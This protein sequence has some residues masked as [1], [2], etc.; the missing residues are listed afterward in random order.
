MEMDQRAYFLHLHMIRKHSNCSYNVCRRAATGANTP[1]DQHQQRS[2]S[3]QVC[4]RAVTGENTPREQHRRV[5][6]FAAVFTKKD[7]KYS[8]MDRKNKQGK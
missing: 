8:N 6:L 1:K 7:L 3:R 2:C 4:H 5:L